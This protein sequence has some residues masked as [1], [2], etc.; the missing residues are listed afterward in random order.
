MNQAQIIDLYKSV[1]DITAHMLAAARNSD[2]DVLSSLESDCAGQ[3]RSL[4]NAESTEHEPKLTDAVQLHKRALIQTILTSNCE[5]SH[6][7]ESRLSE[8]SN[9]LHQA[10]VERQLS[11]A[12][13][14]HQVV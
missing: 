14:S 9:L 3:V 2:W 13:G 12:Y 1:A 4:E 7:A 10:S 6:L 8:L 5:L 11:M